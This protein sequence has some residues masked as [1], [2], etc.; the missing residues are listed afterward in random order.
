MGSLI[1]L[2]RRPVRP[3]KWS[4]AAFSD[5]VQPEPTTTYRF[6]GM[7]DKSIEAETSAV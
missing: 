1:D 7:R 6:A 4:S 5:L 2:P 3:G